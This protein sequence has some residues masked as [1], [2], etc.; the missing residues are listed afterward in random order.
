M[1]GV[2]RLPATL[3]LMPFYLGVAAV[4]GALAYLTNSILPSMVLHAG[5]NVLGAFDLF[6]RG[7][8]EWQGLGTPQPLIWETDPDASFW[9]SV[10]A[11]LIVGAAAV[12]AYAALAR[13]RQ[14]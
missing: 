13:L 1:N 14:R 3:V 7:H 9:F 8:S 12:W 2:L 5:G 6:A 11:T 4:Y 10:G